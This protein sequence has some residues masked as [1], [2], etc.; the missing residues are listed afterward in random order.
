MV[1]NNPDFEIQKTN[2]INRIVDLRDIISYDIIFDKNNRKVSLKYYKN[3]EENEW[4]ELQ[5]NEMEYDQLIEKY[6]IHFDN[7]LQPEK[8]QLTYK[9]NILYPI[10]ID[11]RPLLKT[12]DDGY[13]S[14][15]EGYI[16]EL[17][18]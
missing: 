3:N 14:P 5:R 17:N 6:R 10:F 12:Y 15:N 1:Q 7:Y 13:E 11:T 2:L 8:V 9:K 18:R 16:K 4:E